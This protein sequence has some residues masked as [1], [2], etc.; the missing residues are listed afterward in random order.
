MN[1]DITND[2]WR[3]VLTLRDAPGV[4][5]PRLHPSTSIITYSLPGHPTWVNAPGTTSSCEGRASTV[6]CSTSLCRS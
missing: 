6:P 1:V 4:Y 2:V 3:Q 5:V